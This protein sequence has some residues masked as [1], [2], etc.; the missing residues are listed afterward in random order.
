MHA[1]KKHWGS[2]WS[3]GRP[4][5]MFSIP[6][7]GNSDEPILSWC[8]QRD[9]SQACTAHWQTE[10]R[11]A[12][13]TPL[14]GATMDSWPDDIHTVAGAIPSLCQ[15]FGGPW[16]STSRRGS[17]GGRTPASQDAQARA[18]LRVPPPLRI[19]RMPKQHTSCL[20][21][22]PRTHIFSHI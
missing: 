1:E 19:I 15:P 5:S 10:S 9:G 8:H 21:T 18:P 3:H 4:G 20:P 7:R 2:N 22:H 6:D 13:A 12:P 11:P 16:P 14:P 17:H